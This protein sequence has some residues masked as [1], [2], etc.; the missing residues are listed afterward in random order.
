VSRF[1]NRHDLPAAIVDAVTNDPYE[2]GGDISATGLIDAPQ[3]RRLLWEHRENIVED[4]ADRVW[5]LFGSAVHHI[6]ER[7]NDPH[8]VTEERLFAKLAGWQV[9]GQ[10][11]RY[12]PDSKK[13]QDYKVTSVR[14][15]QD[16]HKKWEQ[17]LNVYA[18]LARRNG[19]E[20]ESL[21]VVAILRDW[22]A[23][24]ARTDGGYPQS[25]VLTITL[26]VWPDE[27]AEEFI[28]NR[29]SLH[30]RAR[31]GETIQCTDEERWY[32]GTTY[33]VQKPDAK[34]AYRVYDTRE[35]ADENCPDHMVVVERPGTY[36]RC[37]SYCEAAPFCAQWQNTEKS[38]A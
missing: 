15:A 19:M 9:S 16:D 10:F 8:A 18:W 22:K 20:V 5:A 37:E 4:V 17:Q 31:S 26:Q 21:E 2:G 27:I 12:I 29:I 32:T 24:R 6:L 14:T 25:Q 11:D 36:I 23:G 35:E 33:S 38:N 28:R 34:R 13:I 3:R 30:Q 1:T 7:A